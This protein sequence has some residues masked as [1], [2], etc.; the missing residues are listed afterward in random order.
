MQ[1]R[2]KEA[3]VKGGKKR[4]TNKGFSKLQISK[5]PQAGFSGLVSEL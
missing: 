1:K 5:Q 4:I 3:A 2:Q